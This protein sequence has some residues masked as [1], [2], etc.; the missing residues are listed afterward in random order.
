MSR[1]DTVGNHKTTVTGDSLGNLR[2]T[3][4]S[5]TVVEV[6]DGMVTLRDGGWQSKTTKLRMNQASIQYG[7]GFS[8][9]QMDF[10]WFVRTPYD[11]LPVPFKDGMTFKTPARRAV[12]RA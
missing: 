3:Y 12:N 5:T 8:V 2:V 4:H 7:L 9:Y 1:N 10:D 6:K 11:A